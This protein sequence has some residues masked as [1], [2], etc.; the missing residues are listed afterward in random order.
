[1]TKVREYFKAKYD[2]KNSPAFFQGIL[3]TLDIPHED[4][5]TEDVTEK[6][7]LEK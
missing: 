5:L 1:M 4:P 3:R 7:V 6:E 2:K